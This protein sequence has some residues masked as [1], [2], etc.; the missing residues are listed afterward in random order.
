MYMCMYTYMRNIKMYMYMYINVLV[1]SLLSSGSPDRDVF[2][3]PPT[4]AEAVPE[5]MGGHAHHQWHMSDSSGE[6]LGIEAEVGTVCRNMSSTVCA[7]T[8]TCIYMYMYKCTC[9]CTCTQLCTLHLHV[10]M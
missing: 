6:D 10:Y 1:L 9:T 7:C 5:M 8:C 2:S 4:T 3:F